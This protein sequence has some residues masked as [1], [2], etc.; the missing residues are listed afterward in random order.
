MDVRLTQRANLPFST[1]FVLIMPSMD[2]MMPT[3]SG[4]GHLP[5]RLLFHMLVS[6]RDTLTDTPRKDVLSALWASL[7]PVKCTQEVNHHTPE[8]LASP[9]AGSSHPCCVLLPRA[10]ARPPVLDAI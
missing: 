1:L 9:S 5:L 3:H 7:S 4:E 8:L 10:A 2:W 6:S